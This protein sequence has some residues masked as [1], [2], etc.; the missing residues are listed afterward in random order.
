MSK[1]IT[2]LA[3]RATISGVVEGKRPSAELRDQGERGAGR[4]A[5]FVRRTK[6]RVT[7][8]WYATWTR[9]GRRMTAKM[10]SYPTMSLASARKLFRSD[11]LPAILKGENPVGPRGAR[12]RGGATVLELFE[13]YHAWLG[14]RPA[15]KGIKWMLLGKAGAVH[16]IGPHMRAADVRKEHIIPHLAAIHERGSVTQANYVRNTLHA[17]FAYGMRTANSYF[18]PAGAT[19][20]GLEFNPVSVI[21]LNPDASKPRE[22]NLSPAETQSFWR[23][24]EMQGGANPI[25]D[26]MRLMIATGQRVGEILQLSTNH[27]DAQED[28]L[29]W[30]VTKNGRPHCIP[31]PSQ[32]VE[33]LSGLKPNEHGLYFPRWQFP[34]EGAEDYA[35]A[36]L[37]RRYV[38][39]TGAIPF[40]ARDLRRTWKTLAGRAGL[41][42]DIRDRLQNHALRDVSA[43]HY[44]KYDYLPEKRAGMAT[45][46]AYLESLLD[47]GHHPDPAI[48]CAMPSAP[49]VDALAA[50]MGDRLWRAAHQKW[51]SPDWV[52]WPVAQAYRVEQAGDWRRRVRHAIRLLAHYSLIS[53]TTGKDHHRRVFPA[54]QFAGRAP[55][56]MSPAPTPVITHFQQRDLFELE[57]GS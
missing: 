20:W 15:A 2:E 5:L 6:N 36:R 1:L 46:S 33:I 12:A 56:L 41:A 32:A 52:G 53:K 31:L 35:S 21:P 55:T 49:I 29:S 27:Y 45:W 23:W 44:D 9:A 7:S 37:V 34:T 16:T 3:I 40:E 47:E 25:V 42:K 30:R 13:S 28:L 24:L 54:F 51:R 22:R 48:P 11:F 17:A 50:A 38:S 14:D 26:A 19:D 4:L 43:R 10:G 39:E 18:D 8:E 57:N